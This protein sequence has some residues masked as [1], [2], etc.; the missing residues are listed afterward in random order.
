MSMQRSKSDINIQQ[1][2]FEPKQ[3]AQS[4]MVQDLPKKG[5]Q[6]LV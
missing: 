3:L 1:R 4:E 2:M 5:N 6:E